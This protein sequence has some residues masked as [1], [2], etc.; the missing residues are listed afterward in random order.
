MGHAPF[1]IEQAIEAYEPI[2]PGGRLHHVELKGVIEPRVHQLDG[3]SYGSWR[4]RADA[5]G[6]LAQP[7]HDLIAVAGQGV[8]RERRREVLLDEQRPGLVPPGSREEP[9]GGA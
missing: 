7:P 5:T 1:G 6:D 4:R 9:R 8:A 3:D 2:R